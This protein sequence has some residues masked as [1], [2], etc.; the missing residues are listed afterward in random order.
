MDNK[1]VKIMH[2]ADLHLGAEISSL[3]QFADQRRR[4]LF[5]TFE[6]IINICKDESVDFL[7]IAGDLF[8]CV[9][10]DSQSVI[11]MIELIKS[12]P[13]TTIVIASGNHDPFCIDSWFYT[14]SWPANVTFF[15]QE[16]S[17]VLLKEKGVCLWGAGFRSTYHMESF[18]EKE[19]NIPEGDWIHLCVMHGDLLTQGQTS[20]YNPLFKEQLRR[21][22][23]DYM[24]LGHVHK[25]SMI[26]KEGSTFY[27]YS[28]S[29][30]GHGF[31]EMGELGV[32]IGMISKGRCSLQFRRICR[33]CYYEVSIN[34]NDDANAQDTCVIKTNQQISDLILQTIKDRYFDESQDH[35]YKIILT[36]EIPGSFAMDIDG[37]Q[38]RVQNA[39]FYIKIED[40][41]T[42]AI[43]YD[44]IAKEQ[45]LKGIF[46]KKML[47]KIKEA[48]LKKVDQFSMTS[49]KNSLQYGLKAFDGEVALREN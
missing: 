5:F 31:D 29:P 24:A 48:Q 38:Q 11:E 45:T 46:V 28:G 36:G 21:F 32:Y 12:V 9:H 35:L 33:R 1:E 23:F 26:S 18:L 16:L 2:C 25:R 40:Q 19:I 3:G 8:D 10:I 49:L 15:S 42:I 13:E 22:P 41:T 27:S 37:I 30:E 4:E 44:I 17:Y 39:C 14:K 43:D 6:K 20:F 47:E 34:L 7:C